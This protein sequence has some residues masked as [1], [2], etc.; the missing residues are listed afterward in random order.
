MR[1]FIRIPPVIY[2]AVPVSLQIHGI[3]KQ[4][5]VCLIFGR[6]IRSHFSQRHHRLIMENQYARHGIGAIHQ[7]CRAFQYLHGMNIL[8][9]QFNTMF[10]SPLL[11]FLPDAVVHNQHPV[12]SQSPYHRFGNPVARCYLRYAGLLGYYINN[13]GILACI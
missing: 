6:D 7:R 2:K 8:G 5:V 9:I 4:S 13:I 11:S 10:V 12:V 1:H 3:R